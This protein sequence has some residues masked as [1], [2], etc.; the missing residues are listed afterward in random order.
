MKQLTRP[1][2]R[3]LEAEWYSKLED[4]GFKDIEKLDERGRTLKEFHSLKFK[5]REVKNMREWREGYQEMI[6]SFLHHPAFPG[7]C[8]TLSKRSPRSL[9]AKQIARAWQMHCEGALLDDIARDIK[10]A[11]KTVHDTIGRLVQ[12]MKLL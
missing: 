4:S 10:R 3:K 6:D 9:K 8:E 12:W 7:I 1:Q 5:K 11:P 2:F